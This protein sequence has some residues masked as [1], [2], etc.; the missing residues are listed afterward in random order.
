MA[1]NSVKRFRKND[2]KGGMIFVNWMFGE[3][4]NAEEDIKAHERLIQEA[5]RKLLWVDDEKK[6]EKIRQEI[7]WR[8]Q[9]ISRLKK[10]LQMKTS[11]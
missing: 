1:A 11:A 9:E 7:N 10:L 5:L 6:E 4:E 8:M 3:I 2:V